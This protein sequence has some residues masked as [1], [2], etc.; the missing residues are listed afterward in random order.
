MLLLDCNVSC[1]FLRLLFIFLS[2]VSHLRQ[3]AVKSLYK[4]IVHVNVR[5]TCK[6]VYLVRMI[7]DELMIFKI[8]SLTSILSKLVDLSFFN[9]Y[10]SMTY[11]IDFIREEDIKALNFWYG[12]VFKTCQAFRIM[13]IHSKLLPALMFIKRNRKKLMDVYG[14]KTV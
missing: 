9:Y 3:T 14:L 6:N 12:M 13:R 1:Y 7:P 11:K 4:M 10:V 2:A 5:R 8:H